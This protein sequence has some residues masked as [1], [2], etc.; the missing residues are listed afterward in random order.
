MFVPEASHILPELESE[1][2]HLASKYGFQVRH[3]TKGVKFD[4][5][6][7]IFLNDVRFDPTTNLR[8][9][10]GVTITGHLQPADM[11]SFRLADNYGYYYSN[12]LFR[13]LGF[14]EIVAVRGKCKTKYL[15]CSLANYGTTG[16]EE[17]RVCCEEGSKQKVHLHWIGSLVKVS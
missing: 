9:G 7:A 3:R 1:A 2:W 15:Y 6:N 11:R 10:D 16:M 17:S 8:I 4:E 14:I 12:K 13:I 5:K